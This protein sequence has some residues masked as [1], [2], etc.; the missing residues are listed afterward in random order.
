M[1]S[2]YVAAPVSVFASGKENSSIRRGVKGVGHDTAVEIESCCW[3]RN[4]M[5]F[6]APDCSVR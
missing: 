3:T 1:G 5:G 2:I 6:T 4:S